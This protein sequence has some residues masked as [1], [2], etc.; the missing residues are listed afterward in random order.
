MALDYVLFQKDVF[1]AL[2]RLADLGGLDDPAPGRHDQR[3]RA[4]TARF[5]CVI[6]LYKGRVMPRDCAAVLHATISV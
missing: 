3:H 4:G 1:G 6:Q 5:D 2:D